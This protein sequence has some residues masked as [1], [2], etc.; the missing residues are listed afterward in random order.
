MRF[1]KCK[2][3]PM[4]EPEVPSLTAID[5]RKAKNR[6]RHMRYPVRASIEYYWRNKQGLLCQGAGLTRNVSGDGALVV[7]ADCPDEG[8]VVDLTMRVSG[9]RGTIA[10]PTFSIRMQGEIV[11]VTRGSGVEMPAE[12]AVWTRTRHGQS[13]ATEANLSSSREDSREPRMN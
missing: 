8:D 6:R 11:R 13:D 4:K 5:R 12:F 1:E 7:S 2:W 3:A 9:T 10:S